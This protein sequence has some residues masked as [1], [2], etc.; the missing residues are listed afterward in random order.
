MAE[1]AYTA[2]NHS[3][4]NVA[5]TLSANSKREAL[6]MLSEQALFPLQ[7]NDINE[8]RKT[9]GNLFKPSRK[10][11]TELI[12]GTL[13][14]LADLL[15]NGVPLLNSLNVLIEQDIN[16]VLTEVLQDVHDRVI[17]G[18]QL[19]QALAKHEVIF[20][21]LAISM[22]K[23]GSEGAFL[24]DAL[25]RTAAF[26]QLQEELKGRV[27]GAMAYPAFLGVAGLIVTIVLIVYFVP[28]FA[29]LFASLEE[30]G[31][32]PTPTVI[33]LGLSDFLGAYGKYILIV[34]VAIG[35][36]V[37]TYFKTEKGRMALDKWKL[38]IPVA[39]DIFLGTAISR[40]CR[41]LGTLL[42]NGVPLIRALEISQDSTGNRIL[43]KAIGASAEHVTAGDTLSKPL[44]EC[45]LFPKPIM[46]MI[47][48]A[49]ES[50][51]LENVLLNV[52]DGIDR[53]ISA[54]L[55]VMVRLV[56][57]VMLMTM[58]VIVMFILVAL[59]MP[60]FEM[61]SAI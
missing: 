12:A 15:E 41:V 59:L 37:R 46:A 20:G 57:P 58:G 31:G 38:K 16:P 56:E 22:V 48:V 24:E 25:K 32:L 17:D 11:K 55:D 44:N 13:T 3:G 5:G 42:T 6:A 43:G 51:N 61:T 54:Q 9:F 4:K 7:L 36:K 39:G 60:V 52:S 8:K 35:Y 47:N 33:L 1:F 19:D 49:E 23:A 45:G 21:E 26:M 40:F 50:N 14:Q 2:R 10:I 28:K 34:L 53:R 29:E 18:M 30:N 27:K